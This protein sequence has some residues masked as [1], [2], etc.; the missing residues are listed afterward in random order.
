MELLL[1]GANGLGLNHDTLLQ[2]ESTFM[3]T[4]MYLSIYISMHIYIYTHIRMIYLYI[5]CACIYL[6]FFWFPGPIVSLRVFE[7]MDHI[8][9]LEIALNPVLAYQKIS[10]NPEK[11]P[12]Y[13]IATK[14]DYFF[15]EPK[16]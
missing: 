13:S 9:I 16:C 15:L 3:Y 10:K 5:Q 4:C 6:R 2:V 8:A 14:N 11:P 7:A 1:K 12:P